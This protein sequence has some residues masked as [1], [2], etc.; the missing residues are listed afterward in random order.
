MAKGNLIIVTAPSGAG[1]TTLVSDLIEH[2]DSSTPGNRL[3][4]SISHTTRPK[5][6]NEVDGVNYHFIDEAEFADMLQSNEFL[7]QAEVYGYRYGTSR[8][9]VDQQ[10]ADGID[11]IL[12]ID[13]QGANQ[14]RAL[15]P[16]SCY[17]FILPPSLET[18]A[19][20][21]RD[22]GQ[23]DRDTIKDRMR[24]ARSVIL[25][26]SDADYLVVNDD[27]N[28]A[29]ADIQAVI[30]SWRLKAAVQQHNLADLLLSLTRQ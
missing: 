6:H 23:D 8:Q 4:V 17:I 25:H 11:V 28:R 3:A 27:F 30:R 16:D 18:L 9:W 15:Y 7:E 14:I 1:K 24:E 2:S 12:E 29:L 22:R 13:W 21:L 19:E 5:R 20:R 26:A 10:L